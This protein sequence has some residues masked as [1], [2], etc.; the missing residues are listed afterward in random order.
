MDGER[1]VVT[2]PVRHP[3]E[4]QWR[5][6]VIPLLMSVVLVACVLAYRC[7]AHRLKRERLLR[8]Q[9]DERREFTA[10]QDS[11]AGGASSAGDPYRSAAA[12][13]LGGNHYM[14]AYKKLLQQA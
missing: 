2:S 8:E 14:S 11:E 10:A 6:I 12:V 4:V 3:D 5:F 1:T 9:H 7:R 13:G